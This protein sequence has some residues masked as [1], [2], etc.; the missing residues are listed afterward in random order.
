MNKLTYCGI[1]SRQTPTHV[2]VLME[3]I[4]EELSQRGWILRSGHADGA[5]QAFERG[6]AKHAPYSEI[7]L[8]WYGYNNGRE[9]CINVQ[10]LDRWVEARNVAAQFHPAWHRYSTGG[11]LLHTRNVFQFG[12]IQLDKP[13]DC[14]ICWTPKGEITGGT[15]GALRIA[16]YLEIPVFNLGD[17]DM[18]AVLD[19]LAEF[20]EEREK[21]NQ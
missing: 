21:A 3:A 7:F 5:D 17:A 2:L 11:Q 10:G 1:G 13:S 8:P 19:K 4:A 18:N 16:Q 14:V 9:G 6:A 20:V 15:G 12:G